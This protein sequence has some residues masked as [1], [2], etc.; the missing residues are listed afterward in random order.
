MA[1]SLVAGGIGQKTYTVSKDMVTINCIMTFEKG[2]LYE[3]ETVTAFGQFWKDLKGTKTALNGE[4][5]RTI[6]LNSPRLIAD[7]KYH[8][9]VIQSTITLPLAEQK[10]S[11]VHQAM[12]NLFIKKM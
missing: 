7:D 5:F 3:G 8:D 11:Q 6:N 1:K 2:F 9:V 4:G 12:K 10:I